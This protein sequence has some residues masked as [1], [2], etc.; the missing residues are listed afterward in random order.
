MAI[1]SIEREK[2]D[3]ENARNINRLVIDVENRERRKYNDFLN[4][5]KTALD[6]GRE[7][8]KRERD[9]NYFS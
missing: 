1:K 8:I 2:I 3:A 9:K 7:T 5:H 6:K 4:K